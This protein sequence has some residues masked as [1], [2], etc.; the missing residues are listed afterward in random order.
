[1]NIFWWTPWVRPPVLIWKGEAAKF[2]ERW[3]NETPDLTHEYHSLLPSPWS[4]QLQSAPSAG[5]SSPAPADRTRPPRPDRPLLE[6]VRRSRRPSCRA[7]CARSGEGAGTWILRRDSVKGLHLIF[8]LDSQSITF[9]TLTKHKTLISYVWIKT[10]SSA[11]PVAV[12]LIFSEGWRLF[13]F[14]YHAHALKY[15][16]YRAA[17][18]LQTT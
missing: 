5:S 3:V 8:L 17:L 13:G 9:E 14:I 6:G 4:R 10:A 15:L 12:W 1:M 16:N 18:Y 11:V 2:K 7:G